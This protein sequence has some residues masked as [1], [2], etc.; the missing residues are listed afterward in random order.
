MLLLLVILMSRVLPEKLAVPQLV[1]KFRAFYET[2]RSLQH[3]QEPATCPYSEP[4]QFRP[5]PITLL[6]DPFNI[7]PPLTPRSSK[8]SLSLTSPQQNPVSTSAAHTFHMPCPP[9]S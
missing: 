1:K 5:C 8:W 4:D 2:Q 9:H 6:E 3:S 7:I